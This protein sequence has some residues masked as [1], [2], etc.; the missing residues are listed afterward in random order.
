MFEYHA[1]ILEVTDGDTLD[2]LVDLGFDPVYRRLK[3]ARLYGID[4]PEKNTEAGMAAKAYLVNLLP[5]G[6]TIRVNTIK[7]KSGGEKVEKYGGYLVVLHMIEDNDDDPATLSIND[8][9]VA[10]GH[11]KA[12]FGGKRV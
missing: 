4:A 6:T 2:L 3:R 7:V 9:I 8:K 11:A 10:A 1:K 5:V 12:Y